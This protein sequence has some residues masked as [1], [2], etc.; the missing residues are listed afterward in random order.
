[1]NEHAGLHIA[2]CVDVPLVA[3]TC[4]A[5]AYRLGGILEVPRE[6]GCCLPEGTNAAVDF[7]PLFRRRKQFGCSIV[8]YRHVVEEPDK[9]RAA[10]NNRIEKLLTGNV[11][12]VMAGI[13]GGNAKRKLVVF[14]KGP[15]SLNRF[16]G[17][18]AAEGGLGRV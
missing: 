9:Q 2:L 4:N 1:M 18:V 10:V 16:L 7:F 13:A 5:S 3:A 12:I 17:G 11:G 8:T 6:N 14:E 15:G